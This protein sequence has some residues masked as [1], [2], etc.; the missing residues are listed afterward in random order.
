MLS[1]IMAVSLL[2][3]IMDQICDILFKE[4]HSFILKLLLI[5]FSVYTQ[6]SVFSFLRYCKNC[7]LT[8]VE[9]E[10]VANKK[11]APT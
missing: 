4:W 1:F 5:A 8:L 7:L 10:M 3:K 2:K 9:T 6:K 11:W